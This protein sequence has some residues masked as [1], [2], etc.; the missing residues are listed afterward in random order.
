MMHLVDLYQKIEG[1]WHKPSQLIVKKDES[2][3]STQSPI[4][5]ADLIYETRAPLQL[6]VKMTF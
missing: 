6:K 2:K 3:L 4:Y 5:K 1:T